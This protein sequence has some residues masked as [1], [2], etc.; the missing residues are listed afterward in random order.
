M[1]WFLLLAGL[2]LGLSCPSAGA[3]EGVTVTPL[4]L[5]PLPL[6]LITFPSGK[7]LNVAVSPGAGAFRRAG[8]PEGRIWTV[9]DRGP[10]IDCSDQREVLGPEDR[11]ICPAGRRGKIHLLPGFAPSIYAIDVGPDRLARYVDMIP[12]KGA[13][14]RLLTGLANP[15]VHASAEE[16][17][18]PDGQPL[19]ADASAIEPGGLV[20]L[21]DGS[22]W[23]AENFGPSLLEV[24]ADGTVR[25]RLVPTDVAEDLRGADYPVVAALP[26]ILAR[27]ARGRG[28]EGLA[29]TPDEKYLI[30]AMQNALA[31]PDLDTFRSSA[32]VRLIK[33]ERATGVVVA[34]YLYGLDPPGDFAGEPAPVQ[35]AA[36]ASDVR[37]IEIACADD[38]RLLVLERHRRQV[39]LYRIDLSAAQALS[40]VFAVSAAQPSLEATP[41]AFWQTAGMMP[42]V[43]TLLADSAR[44]KAMAGKINGMAVMSDRDLVL[45]GNNDFG[46]DGARAQMFR[47]TFPASI[48]N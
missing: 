19:A 4:S 6:G 38:H 16:V 22:F 35:R 20:R 14:G 41:R 8:D 40:D 24:A 7:A 47:L 10:T 12:L 26:G 1:R 33:I 5:P 9:T 45:V 29:V 17:F 36:Q 34:Q 27:R 39:R 31:N 15:F 18:A 3:G 48:L 32:A 42:V 43:K 25:R 23:V 30:V 13:S 44:L 21:R 2:A 11:A 37:L 28:F 46:S